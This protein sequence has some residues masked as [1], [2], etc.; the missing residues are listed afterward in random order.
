MHSKNETY[1][2]LRLALTPHALNNTTAKDIVTMT[3]ERQS[4]SERHEK[5]T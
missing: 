1:A 5:R 3:K 2:V 4:G